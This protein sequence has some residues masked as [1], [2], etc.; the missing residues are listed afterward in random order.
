MEATFLTPLFTGVQL[1][2][3]ATSNGRPST[4]QAHFTR[5]DITYPASTG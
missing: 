3:Y 1:G 4:N 5:F 2:L